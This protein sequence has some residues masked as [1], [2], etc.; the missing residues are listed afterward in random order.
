MQVSNFF[1]SNTNM[2]NKISNYL[3]ELNFNEN[4][5][6]VYLALAELGEARA[7]QVAKL[8]D[9]PRT[10]AISILDKFSEE[11]YITVHMY[12]GAKTYW[13]ESPHVLLDS[14]S[15]KIEIA[16]KLADVLPEVYRLSGR[17]P[18]A[19]VFDTKKGIKNVVEKSLNS[20]KKGDII[21]TIDTPAEGNYSKIFSEHIENEFFNIKKRK[22][23]ITKTLVPFNTY[24]S[25]SKP[26]LERQHIVIKVMPEEINFKGSLWLI[27]DKLFN[28]SGNP[29]FLVLIEHGAIV[30]G[31]RSIYNY[32][33]KISKDIDKIQ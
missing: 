5:I 11:N 1:D 31:M 14:L 2:K 28:F 25:I 29:P 10:T 13:V 18:S 30:E 6:K 21:Y 32:L 15:N 26:K 3:K 27:K 17:F 23:I 4:E 33:W 12:K 16:K 8:A 24:L 7:S 19:N 22:G 20:M 9:V